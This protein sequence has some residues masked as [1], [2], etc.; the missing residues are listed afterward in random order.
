MYRIRARRFALTFSAMTAIL[1][2]N[3]DNDDDWWCQDKWK[4]I[5]AIL[6]QLP[7]IE[8]AFK[9]MCIDGCDGAPP[10]LHSFSHSFSGANWWTCFIEFLDRIFVWRLL[11]QIP[12]TLCTIFSAFH[13]CVA[14]LLLSRTHWEWFTQ[15]LHVANERF[16][17]LL[18]VRH[19]LLIKVAKSTF[20]W[21]QWPNILV[22]PKIALA[23]IGNPDRDRQI[24]AIPIGARSG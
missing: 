13:R 8:M 14:W 5:K 22:D 11:T 3:D 17:F 1:W 9:R 20:F 15:K 24:L 18:M 7:M 23:K 2:C 19:F 12:G 16:C 6:S 10:L 21:S 4:K